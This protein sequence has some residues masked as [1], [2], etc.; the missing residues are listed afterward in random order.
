MNDRPCILFPGSSTQ[1]LAEEIANP[2]T[3]IH[4]GDIY[5][6]QFASGE[7]W[8]QL[9][10]NVRGA[11]VFLLQS[12][13]V[14]A[15]DN[16][17]QL[18]VMADAARR[19]SADRITAVIPYFGYARQDRK[20]KPRVPITAKLIMDLLEAADIDRVITMD[21]HAQQVQGFTNLP[22]DHLYFQPVLANAIKSNNIQVV[23][24]PDIGAVKKASEHADKY[25]LDIAFITKKRKSETTVE[26][27][28]FV[29]DVKDKNVIILDDL[30]E[31]AGTI[32]AAVEQCFVNGA[33]NIYAAVTHGCLSEVGYERLE[34]LHTNGKLTHFYCSN[35]AT[36]KKWKPVKWGTVISIADVFR[37]AISGTHY[38]HS[39]TGLFK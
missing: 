23:V 39:I 7:F 31:S 22:F 29:G 19:A 4:L 1:M 38:N 32:E 27:N 2:E 9:K 17:M 21:I 37:K 18:L 33:K 24:S 6:K 11:D 8:C 14:P 20:D 5:H 35:T 25:G 15:N 16:V 36:E 28:Q 34:K 10:E 30:T 26:V 13:C 3:G 12:F